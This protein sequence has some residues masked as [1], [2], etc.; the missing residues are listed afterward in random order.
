MMIMDHE[1]PLPWPCTCQCWGQG[2]GDSW[3]CL[4]N[5]QIV[6]MHVK[7]R[8]HF[9]LDHRLTF[10][11]FAKTKH[12]HTGHWAHEFVRESTFTLRQ[13]NTWNYFVSMTYLSNVFCSLVF[14]SS[15]PSVSHLW[16]VC[17]YVCV[18]VVHS[19][20]HKN[21]RPF[22]ACTL[23][24]VSKLV[25]YFV[26]GLG[27]RKGISANSLGGSQFTRVNWAKESGSQ[28]NTHTHTHTQE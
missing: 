7:W 28:T 24:S 22:V 18:C 27:E 23:Y 5:L 17:K 21:V 20:L 25:G 14:Y 1:S 9:H 13:L 12:T 3:L 6:P 26:S 11:S 4:R 2:E 15:S 19:V 16:Y 8:T 10:T